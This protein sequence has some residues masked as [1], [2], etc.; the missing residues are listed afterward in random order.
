VTLFEVP[1][2]FGS[3]VLV[4]FPAGSAACFIPARRATLVDPVTVLREE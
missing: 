1:L 2:V 3:I 4:L